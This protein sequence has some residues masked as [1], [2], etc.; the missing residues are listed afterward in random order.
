MISMS[1]ED[2]DA[3]RFLWVD[4]PLSTNPNIII[5]R[6]ARVV[7]GVSASPY[8]LNSTIQHH[9][10]QYSSLQPDIV[11]KLLESFYVDDLV[12]GGND[13]DEA[14]KHYT[15]ARNASQAS[16]NLRKF[17]TNSHVLRDRVKRE[18]PHL[19]KETADIT[20]TDPTLST[21]Q[22]SQPDEHKVLGVRWNIQTDQLIFELSA[23]AESTVTLL[24]IKRKM[25]SL[26]GRFYDPLGF[27]SP[28]VIKFKVLVQEL[29]RSQ[30]NWDEPLTGEILKKWKDLNTDLMKSEPVAMDRHYFTEY[31]QTRQYQLFGFC[32]G[33]TIAYA[34]VIYLVEVTSTGKHSSFVVAKTRV[35]PL[36]VQ[37]IPRLELLSALL[38]ARLMKNVMDSMATRLALDVPRCFTDSQIA[39][40][41]IKGTH[42]DWKPFIQ[43]RTNKIRRLVPVERWDHCTGKSNPADMPSRGLSSME[44]STNKLWKHGPDWLQQDVDTSPLSRDPRCMCQ[45]AEV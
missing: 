24:P 27:L 33:S 29:C 39:L 22:L 35:S 7:F 25:I 12:C 38:L 18:E 45:R 44:L 34:A 10:M 8:L 13:E 26:I 30:V 3:L 20:Y 4:D 32:D 6:F 11:A 2:R 31:N 37:T 1:P 41:W 14:H 9:L 23:I 42:K 15:F 36:K 19:S 28:I 40:Y 5:Y 43:N 16:F 17:I 21:E